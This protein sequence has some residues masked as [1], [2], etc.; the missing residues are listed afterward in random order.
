MRQFA[1][2]SKKYISVFGDGSVLSLAGLL[3]SF[4]EEQIASEKLPI[5]LF[6]IFGERGT[7]K[8]EQAYMLRHFNGHYQQIRSF[9]DPRVFSGKSIVILDEFSSSDDLSVEI[10]KSIYNKTLREIKREHIQ[11]NNIFFYVGQKLPEDIA[12]INKSILI[13]SDTSIMSLADFQNSMREMESSEF[14]LIIDEINEAARK[15]D[16]NAFVGL[17]NNRME[18]YLNYTSDTRVAQNHAVV[19]ASIKMLSVFMNLGF[20]TFC[21]EKEL[22]CSILRINQSYQ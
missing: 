13:E 21:I 1:E 2:F 16:R 22:I 20:S 8:T 9:F 5:P 6:N 19:F 17:L 3:M 12:L 4:N 11:I 7:G 10:L 15:F 18:Y 14:N